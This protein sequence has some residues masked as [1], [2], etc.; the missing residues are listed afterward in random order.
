MTLKKIFSTLLLAAILCA[1]FTASAQV[2]IGSD[3]APSQWS[4]LDLCTREQQRALHNARMDSIQRNALVTPASPV[5]HRD[6]AQGLMLFNTDT[7][8][9]E[10]WSGTRWVSLC[11]GDTPDPCAG[12]ADMYV[13]FCI[14]SGATIADLTAAARAAG[15][16]GT[17]VWYSAAEGGTRFTN[18]NTPLVSGTYYAVN[19][20]DVTDRVPVP[21]RFVNCASIPVAAGRIAAFVNV[22]YDF[23]HQRLTAFTNAGGQPTSWQWQMRVRVGSNMFGNGG[24]LLHD[25]WH[26]ITLPSARTPN[27]TIPADFMYTYA[28]IPKGTDGQLPDASDISVRGHRTNTIIIEFRCRITNPGTVVSG[29]VVYRY[30]EPLSILFIRTNTSGFGGS[31]NARFLTI[32]R[33][34]HNNDNSNPNTIRMALLNVGATYDDGIGLGGFIQWGRRLDGHE[35]VVWRIPTS[36]TTRRPTIG[37]P[38]DWGGTSEI[39]GR[40]AVNVNRYDADG[41]V[42]YTATQWYSHFITG[43]GDWGTVT[44]GRNNLWGNDLTVNRDNSPVSLDGATPNWSERARNNN[45]CQHLGAGWRVPSGAELGDMHSSNGIQINL[46][47]SSSPVTGTHNIWTKRDWQTNS[48]GGMVITNQNGE[49]VFLPAVGWRNGPTGSREGNSHGQYWTSTFG[50]VNTVRSMHFHSGVVGTGS[51]G[52]GNIRTHGFSV[53]CVQ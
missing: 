16:R 29:T 4:L 18:P 21:V 47:Q 51:L 7:D 25:D 22:M 49:S 20:V 1:P 53:R 36:G 35:H 44:T 2:T 15:G 43:N 23:Q 8:C 37:T 34:P 12:F 50:D 11:E 46:S 33:I 40:G 14:G 3:R 10:F 5:N 24:E 42:R 13:A 31:G 32:N 45:P 41:Q 27:F 52:V 19:C 28:R 38:S 48:F 6:S 17:V 26:D 39:V 9:L 30:T